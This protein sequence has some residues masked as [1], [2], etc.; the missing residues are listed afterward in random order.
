MFFRHF[1]FVPL[2]LFATTT[3]LLACTG[4]DS[5]ALPLPDA[6]PTPSGEAGA[7]AGGAHEGGAGD[8][9]GSGDAA[10]RDEGDGAESPTD[11]GG[12]SIDATNEG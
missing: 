1:A 7:E 8:A 6:G 3:G 9:G 12:A 11:A 2:F 10:T 5:A 4:D